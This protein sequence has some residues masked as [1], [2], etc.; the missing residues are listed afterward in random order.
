M[1]KLE[2]HGDSEVI[3]A[4]SFNVFSLHEV[5][6]V[7][8]QILPVTHGLLVLLGGEVLAPLSHGGVRNFLQHWIDWVSRVEGVGL[9]HLELTVVITSDEEPVSSSFRSLEI[10]L[11]QVAEVCARV[12]KS[13]KRREGG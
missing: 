1:V 8:L 12:A 4:A 10:A 7:L 9:V 2:L 13:F 11:E 5:L 3:V 6:L